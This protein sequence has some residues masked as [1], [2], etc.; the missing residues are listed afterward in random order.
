MDSDESHDSASLHLT[1]HVLSRHFRVHV[2]I[3]LSIGQQGKQ[4]KQVVSFVKLVLL[5]FWKPKF[6]QPFE[7]EEEGKK[8]K[9]R[10]AST[11]LASA[12]VQHCIM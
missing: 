10:L 2:Y 9:R 8:L 4:V 12:C 5:R 3:S 11:I 1:F 6:A 7:D